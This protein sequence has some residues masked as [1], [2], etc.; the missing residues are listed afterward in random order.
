MIKKTY[1]EQTKEELIQ[2]A[3]KWIAEFKDAWV[4]VYQTSDGDAGLLWSNQQSL[5]ENTTWFHNE[6]HL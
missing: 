4:T 5:P 6:G 2:T 3:K 1:K